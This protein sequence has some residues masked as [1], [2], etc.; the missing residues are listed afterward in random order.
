V[1]DTVDVD[2]AGV[3]AGA[4]WA[5]VQPRAR[6]FPAPPGEGVERFRIGYRRVRLSAGPDDL[7]SEEIGRLDRGDEV[8]V[9]DAFEGCLQVRTPDGEIGWIRRN[10]IV[11]LATQLDDS[12][13]E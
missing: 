13:A 9:L 10:T 2:T 7:R 4:G 11:G 1:A 8:E 12:G 5:V 3:A 6:V